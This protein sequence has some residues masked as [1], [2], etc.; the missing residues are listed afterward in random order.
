MYH[1]DVF[2]DFR[3][4]DWWQLFIYLP[5]FMDYFL[6]TNFI[7]N[8]IVSTNYSHM[9]HILCTFFIHGQ[10]FLFFQLFWSYYCFQTWNSRYLFNQLL[11]LA[12]KLLL[13]IWN[14]TWVTGCLQ[15]SVSCSLHTYV[16]ISNLF[17]HIWRL[18]DQL[19]KLWR[20]CVRYMINDQISVVWSPV[21]QK[22]FYVSQ[23]QCFSCCCLT[24]FL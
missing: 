9:A 18:Q 17:A 13:N 10:L 20:Q 2:V 23:F 7:H 8:E 6:Q 5:F 1:T 24:S 15:N 11:Q 16:I 19:C 12:C 3:N 14:E 22:G 21:I 4:A